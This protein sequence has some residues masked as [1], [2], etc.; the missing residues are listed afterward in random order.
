[1][2]ILQIQ[3]S[4]FQINMPST[5]WPRIT[6]AIIANNVSEDKILQSQHLKLPIKI[7]EKLLSYL[8]IQL[9]FN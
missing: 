5:L 4:S 6:T 3:Q 9:N 2:T 8:C 1:M 7:C